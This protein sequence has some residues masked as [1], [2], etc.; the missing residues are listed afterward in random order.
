M[1]HLLLDFALA[2]DAVVL[3]DNQ[4]RLLAPIFSSQ[5]MVLSSL[6]LL[7]ITI[8]PLLNAR[9]IETRHLA[10]VAF[11][12][13]AKVRSERFVRGC[14][15]PE[16]G[17]V[18]RAMASGNGFLAGSL[19]QAKR[20]GKAVWACVRLDRRRTTISQAGGFPDSNRGTLAFLMPSGR[21]PGQFQGCVPGCGN[22]IYEVPQMRRGEVLIPTGS[23]WAPE[24]G[25]AMLTR[26]SPFQGT[27][28]PMEDSV[29]C[30]SGVPVTW[31]QSE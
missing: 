16:K 29:P 19:P 25:C 28:N 9:T 23:R 2:P 24:R 27:D 13:F 11:A 30:L 3:G 5:D 8:S 7:K 10:S 17:L 18:V 20:G 14:V 1:E 4:A 22:G 15:T 6:L 21:I 26:S 12:N 31:E